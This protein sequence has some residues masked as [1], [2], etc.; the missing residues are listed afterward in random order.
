MTRYCEGFEPDLVHSGTRTGRYDGGC[1]DVV[2]TLKV[3]WPS[4][5]VPTMSVV[6][7][8]VVAGERIQSLHSAVTGWSEVRGRPGRCRLLAHRDARRRP[9]T[10][11]SRPPPLTSIRPKSRP[12]SSISH[13]PR[14]TCG[15]INQSVSGQ[16]VR[17]RRAARACTLTLTLHTT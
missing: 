1:Y 2:L 3:S 5:P 8:V 10:A 4:P 9:P 15:K 13:V 14:P 11:D 12:P 6:V 16:S 17:H 7:E